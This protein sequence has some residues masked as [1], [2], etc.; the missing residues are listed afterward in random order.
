MENNDQNYMFEALK[1]A[2]QAF[3]LG[4]VPVGAVLVYQ[5]QIIGRAH[6]IVES[7]QNASKHAEMECLRQGTEFL[8]NWRLL[9][10][11]LYCTLEPCAMC[12]GALLLHRVKRLV[13]GAPDLRHGAHGSWVNLLDQNH[14]MHT[15][16]VSK[17]VLKEECALLMKNFFMKRRQESAK[18]P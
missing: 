16:E 5:G 18:T 8:N 17:G 10:T 14:P 12:A 9:G 13:W 2:K 1:E 11:T 3:S 6:N 4:E 15:L 7:T